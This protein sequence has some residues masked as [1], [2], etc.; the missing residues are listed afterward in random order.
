MRILY[1]YT[2]VAL[3]ES[4]VWEYSYLHTRL[5]LVDL[6]AE[7]CSG[8]AHYRSLEFSPFLSTHLGSNNKK[9]V[10][11]KQRALPSTDIPVPL[12]SLDGCLPLHIHVYHYSHHNT[13]LLHQTKHARISQALKKTQRQQTPSKMRMPLS[14][15][16]LQALQ[17]LVQPYY[18]PRKPTATL[19]Q[20]H[21]CMYTFSSRSDFTNACS[22]SKWHKSRS[23]TH[24]IAVNKR[25]L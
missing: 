3:W 16:L 9:F 23:S 4:S 22:I 15:C 8:E 1:D 20:T 21:V 14:R 13:P 6:W 19:R 7:S 25:T 2:Y 11:Y 10:N 24:A 18:L 17:A 5:V 12:T